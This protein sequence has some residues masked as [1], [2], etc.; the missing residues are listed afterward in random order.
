MTRTTRLL[1]A[2]AALAGVLAGA[3]ACTT[4]D[5]AVAGKPPASN[6]GTAKEGGTLKVGLD[7]PFGKLDPADAT[8]TSQPMFLLANALF[9]PLMVN[10]AAG[11]VHPYLAKSFTPNADATRWTLELTPGVTFSNGAPLDAQAVVA[12]V[13]RLTKPETKCSC[14]VD[15]ATIAGMAAAGPT[16]VRFDL[17]APNATFPNLFTRALGYIAAPGTS[18]DAVVGSGPFTVASSQTGVSVTVTKNANYWGTKPH[19]DRVEYKVLPDTDSRYQSLRSGDT[20]LIWTETPS[21]HKQAAAD[22]LRSATAPAAVSVALL[23]TTTAPFDD[24]RVRQAMQYA[25]DREAL[26]KVVNLGQGGVADGPL[27]STSPYRKNPSYPG[28]DPA[29]AKALLAESGKQVSFDYLVPSTPASQQRATVIQQMLGDVGIKMTVKPADAAAQATALGQ[30]QF[31]ALDFT[32]SILG[33]TDLGFPSLFL[34]RSPF[35]FTGFTTPQVE[36]ALNRGRAA[37]DAAAR[38]TAYDDVAKAVV[39][40]APMLFLTENRVGYIASGKVGGVP[41]LDKATVLNLSPTGLWLT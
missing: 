30:R 3:S 10:D 16:T 17:K 13:T 27:L 19:V 37:L 23:N 31:Q 6:G 18:P 1:A 34:A 25:I 2:T 33:D 24:A 35:N 11:G 32:T 26:L 21:Q 22:G 20:D 40:D 7:R 39:R 5:D 28:F 4:S 9:D 8:L 36:E 14:I 12:H 29:K 15:A 38:G 41:A